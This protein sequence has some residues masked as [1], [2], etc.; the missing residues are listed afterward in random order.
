M[1][2]LIKTEDPSFVRDKR[3][4]A[5]LNTDKASYTQFRMERERVLQMQRTAQEVATL[6]QDMKEIK[7]LLQLLING[8]T[9][10]TSDI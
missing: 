4:T 7:Q 6:Q 10:G 5:I 3:S 8:K 1:M 9:N 2:E